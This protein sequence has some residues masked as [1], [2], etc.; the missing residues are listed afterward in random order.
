MP[1]TNVT[2][3][4]DRRFE[5][6]GTNLALAYDVNGLAMLLVGAF[7]ADVVSI[8]GAV[9]RLVCSIDVRHLVVC[10]HDRA[11]RM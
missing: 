5:V 10:V 2:E 7:D 8:N 3:I 11:Q 6:T 4:G 1:W 9:W